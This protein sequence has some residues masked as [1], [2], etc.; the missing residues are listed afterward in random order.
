MTLGQFCSCG[1][2]K[3]WE[4]APAFRENGNVKTSE[5]LTYGAGPVKNE[6]P[7]RQNWDKP[8]EFLL[9]CIAMSVGL[10]NLWR[11]PVTAF[12]NGGG[13]FLIPYIIVLFV[14]GKPIY[15][16]E[17]TL[18]Q[19]CSCGQVKVWEIAPAFRVLRS[20]D[21]PEWKPIYFMEMTLGQFCS[22][23]QVKVWEIAPAFR[24]VG[25]AMMVSVVCL[26]TYY[27]SLMALSAFYFFASFTSELPWSKCDPSWDKCMDSNPSEGN[28]T[29]NFTSYRSSS[30]IYFLDTVIHQKQ[31]IN[32]GIGYP[33]WRL[34][35]CLIF[36]WAL[37][38]LVLAKGVQSSGKAAYFMALFPYI[39]LVALLIKG[40][41]LPGAV[42]GILYF[43]TPRFE[44]LLNP[45]VNIPHTGLQKIIL[46]SSFKSFLY[47]LCDGREFSK[48]CNV[49]CL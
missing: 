13:A 11:F 28:Y 30:E 42:N 10:G 47:F 39:V 3:V 8:I 4:I 35:L 5:T 26:V 46:H 19:F 44:E 7:E 1:Q 17:M 21:L 37:I 2:V 18:G 48:C 6:A 9:S 43:I 23:G 33:E 25:W 38:F 29:K 45:N 20:D 12:E 22:C 32:D 36:S 15:F 40:A 16:M 27:C 14:I 41:T 24:G 31:N 49:V 34:V